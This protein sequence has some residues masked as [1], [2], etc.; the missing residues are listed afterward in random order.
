MFVAHKFKRGLNPELL[1]LYEVCNEPPVQSFP[2][3]F[4]QLHRTE[5]LLKSRIFEGTVFHR[6][7]PLADTER[8]SYERPQVGGTTGGSRGTPRVGRPIPI[9]P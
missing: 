6:D 1:Q 4:N 8:S 5:T 2:L 7:Q 9:V 3:L